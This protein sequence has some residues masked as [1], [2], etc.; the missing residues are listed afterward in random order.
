MDKAFTGRCRFT[1]LH[2]VRI[3]SGTNYIG[4]VMSCN[5][6]IQ[7]V[8]PKKTTDEFPLMRD[9]DSWEKAFS[10]FVGKFTGP[11]NFFQFSKFLPYLG[12]AWLNYVI[13]TFSLQEG[14]VFIK[15]PSVKHIDRFFELFPEAKLLLLLRD[16]RDNV[17]STVKAG[18]AVRASTTAISKAKT[19]V[20]HLLRR[21]FSSAARDWAAGVTRIERF[22]E[23]FKSSPFA[24]RYMIVRYEDVFRNP[25]PMAERIFSFM[26]VPYDDA[27]LEAVENADVV[28]SSFYGSSGRE[29]AR[30][31]NW[32]ATPKTEAFQPTGRWKRWNAAEKALFN[33][34]AGPQLVRM[35]YEDN[36][37]W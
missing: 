12:S 28:G 24:S 13:D 37:N 1:F 19:R 29:D 31:P 16:G 18:L 34:L 15:D 4:K 7:L 35:G 23:Q 30:K 33:R 21:D 3:R 5:P 26:E 22:D 25:R 9:L 17:A 36:L 32:T 11:K 20:N 27:I 8:P 6:H 10:T 14:P 2:G